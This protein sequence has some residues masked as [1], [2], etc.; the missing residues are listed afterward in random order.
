MVKT[1]SANA[2]DTGSI[3]GGGRF[4]ILWSML[5]YYGACVLESM[6]HSKRE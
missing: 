1:P 4:R 2:E 3:P 5:S 6:L